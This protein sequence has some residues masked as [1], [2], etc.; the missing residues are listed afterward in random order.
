MN[1]SRL[2]QHVAR[3]G[4]PGPT[5]WVVR[6]VSTVMAGGIDAARVDQGVER[7]EALAAPDLDRADLAD[8]VVVG[9]AARGLEV[10]DAERDVDQRRPD[11]RRSWPG[12]G[13]G[14]APDGGRDRRGRR[15]GARP[16]P[17]SC[18]RSEQV[19]DCQAGMRPGPALGSGACRP[20]RSTRDHSAVPLPR[21]RQPD[22]VRRDHHPDG[23]RPSTTTPSAA[24]SPSR[25]P[26][27]SPRRST[28]VVCRWC[29]SGAGVEVLAADG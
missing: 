7:A 25:T 4:A 2:G 20:V 6:P 16:V 26:R 24:S 10:E 17:T 21:L 22:P 8:A 27:C 5:I 18:H 23:A 3:C 29:N 28:T 1:S 11:G 14:A 15:V 13:C 12:R 19:F 9:R